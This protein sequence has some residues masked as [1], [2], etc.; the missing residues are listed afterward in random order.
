M[1]KEQELRRNNPDYKP[2]M[3]LT[4]VPVIPPVTSSVDDHLGHNITLGKRQRSS[5]ENMTDMEPQRQSR[6]VTLGMQSIHDIPRSDSLPGSRQLST[7]IGRGQIPAQHTISPSH[8]MHL[9]V[10]PHPFAFAPPFDPPNLHHLGIPGPQHFPL[11]LPGTPFPFAPLG[12]EHLA[13]PFTHHLSPPGL[14]EDLVHLIARSAAQSAQGSQPLNAIHSQ[15]APA[16][17]PP[18]SLNSIAM[19]MWAG[20]PPESFPQN[21]LITEGTG[22][23]HPIPSY[24]TA[25]LAASLSAGSRQLEKPVNESNPVSPPADALSTSA[26]SVQLEESQQSSVTAE[27]DTTWLK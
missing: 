2:R 9:P 16:I 23:Y 5:S 25:A 19:M 10:P 7:T 18:P 8:S 12:G 11:P 3:P 15:E 22:I 20:I 13:F 4:A 21:S 17:P 24:P 14:N 1:A 27:V 6:R 26:T